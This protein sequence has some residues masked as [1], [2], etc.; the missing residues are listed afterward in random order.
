MVIENIDSSETL[1]SYKEKMHRLLRLYNPHV[2]ENDIEEILNYSI[3]KRLYN[4]Q[5]LISNSYKRTMDPETKKYKDQVREFTL[6]QISDYIKRRKPILTAHGT[7]FKHHGEVPNP[8]GITIQSFL[9]LRG[10][11]KKVMFKYPKGSEDFEKY[12]LLQVLDKIDANGIYGVLGMYTSLLYNVNVA[13]SITSQGRAL[14]SS[15][16]MCFEMFLANNVKFGSVDEVLQYI[17]NIISERSYRKFKDKNI[18][19][20]NISLEDCF[21]KVI[22]TCGYRWVPTM[23]DLEIIWN[24][25]SRLD[26]EDLNRIYY[27]NNLYEF[28]S[29]S[30]VINLIKTILRTLDAPLYNSLDIPENVQP[31]MQELCNLMMEFVYYRYQIIDRTDR[32]DNMIKS[33]VMVSDTDSTIISLDAWY[34]FIGQQIDGEELK[35]ANFIPNPLIFLKEK[36]DGTYPDDWKE[37]ISFAPKRFDYNF[38]NEE[39]L[40]GGF[41]LEDELAPNKNVKFTIINILAFVL[42]R[43]INDYMIEFCKRTN[44]VIDKENGIGIHNLNRPCKI[45]MKNEFLFDRLM[46]TMNKKSYASLVALQEG[47]IIP[48]DK[49][50]DVKGIECFVKSTKKKST[51]DRLKKILQEDILTAGTIDQLQ[52]IKDLAIFEKEIINSIRGGSKEYFKPVTIKSASSYSDPMRIQGIK[53]STVWNELKTQDLEAIDLSERNAIDIVKVKINKL[54]VENIKDSYPEIYQKIIDLF[55]KDEELGISTS[56]DENGKKKRKDN[57]IYKGNIDAIAVPLD[58]EVPDWLEEF[59]DYNSIVENNIGGFPIESIG[60]QKLGRSNTNYTNIIT[61]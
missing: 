59:I 52:V 6:L 15:A 23:D 22:L 18:I 10:I 45:L 4:S 11:H 60:V 46:M 51:K 17:D 36:D 61:L 7:M 32:C 56:I 58:V 42:D 25:M 20:E 40:D 54:T 47:N 41:L 37:S 30:Y 24:V 48:E 13:S 9:D 14:I 26:R 21:A 57:R 35:I 3:N 44:S 27:K 19:D 8:L 53:A 43:V 34:R 49:K 50:L 28:T 33:V 2:S 31:Y 38:E 16:T 29:N 1:S 5:A 39:V 12:N 55:N